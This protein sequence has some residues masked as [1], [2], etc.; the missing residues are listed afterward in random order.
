MNGR[1][2]AAYL[3]GINDRGKNRM[4]IEP[5]S[6]RAALLIL[7]V[8]STQALPSPGQPASSGTRRKSARLAR[9]KTWSSILAVIA[10]SRGRC[11][12]RSLA[13]GGRSSKQVRKTFGGLACKPPWRGCAPEQE[14]GTRFPPR[15]VGGRRPPTSRHP[16]GAECSRIATGPEFNTHR[17]GWFGCSSAWKALL[18]VD[19]YAPVSPQID[20]NR[21]GTYVG[22]SLRSFSIF[23]Y[24]RQGALR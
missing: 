6:P 1:P 4:E 11:S 9:A 18:G 21:S 22:H 24:D 20:V 3:H 16:K 23:Q 10:R 13:S 7:G 8:V 2:S 12:V 5:P 15:V 17:I 19:T 14:R